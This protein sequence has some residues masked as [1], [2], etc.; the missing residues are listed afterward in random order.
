MA[1]AKKCDVCGTLYEGYNAKN[2]SKKVNGMM[3]LNIDCHGKYFSHETI[4][5]CPECLESIQGH[6]R[7]LKVKQND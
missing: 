2:D 4:D 1:S 3:F 5:C 6:I 7:F